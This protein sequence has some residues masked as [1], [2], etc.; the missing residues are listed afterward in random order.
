M[1]FMSFLSSATLL[2][3][4]AYRLI[5]WRIK[6]KRTN[7]FV[8]LI[9]NLLLADIQQSFA[10]LLNVEWVKNDAVQIEN[11]ICFLQG[12]LV[13]TGDLASG[14]WCF[15][16]GLHTFA[17]VI[18]DFRLKPRCFFQTVLALW[19]FVYLVSA[20]PVGMYS[21]EVYV[22]SGIWCWIHHDLP[23][24]RLWTH[25]IWIFIFEFGNV[26]VY[27][28]IYTIVLQ[29]IRSGYYSD[30]AAKRARSVSNLMVVYPIVYVVCT[31]PLA[32]ARMAAMSNAPPSNKRLCLA[33]AMITSNGWLDVLLYTLTRRIMIF[34]DEP[35]PENNGIDT[36]SAFW[37]SEKRF[38][39]VCTVEA[40]PRPRAT[41]Q[42]SN[43]S[44]FRGKAPV[45]LHTESTSEEAIHVVGSKE[46]MTVRETHIVSE[47]AQP[48]DY[49]ALEE[50]AR[51]MRPPTPTGRW[52]EEMA[53]MKDME[54][55][56]IP[57]D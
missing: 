27:A 48:E 37:S 34:S 26:I 14:V 28:I 49:L 19:A 17:S 52:S 2:T 55:A 3:L 13:S 29:R 9:F 39:G 5:K 51:R 36:F 47:P 23:A 11:P 56:Y 21:R 45:V 12:W 53:N 18:F 43:H 33:G 44:L 7:Q 46:I 35:P 20:V 8:F 4:L 42:V 50:E 38:G 30:A 32:S 31:L 57:D 25:Y 54:L 40:M 16:I 10:F 6:S 15:A 41:R 22:R 24:L 1:G